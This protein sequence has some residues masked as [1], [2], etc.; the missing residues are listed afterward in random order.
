M[1]L[2]IGLQGRSNRVQLMVKLPIVRPD[3]P[4]A[5]AIKWSMKPSAEKQA[6]MLHGAK[7]LEGQI[8]GVKDDNGV[9]YGPGGSDSSL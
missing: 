4:S 5:F 2:G 9:A 7:P 1:V 8:N 6:A 3:C